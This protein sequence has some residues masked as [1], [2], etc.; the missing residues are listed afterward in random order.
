[1]STFF[2]DELLFSTAIPSVEELRARSLPSE[3]YEGYRIVKKDDYLMWKKAEDI[4]GDDLLV[5][6]DGDCR[7][8]LLP[9]DARLNALG[10]RK[11]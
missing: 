7:T 6:F 4:G 8:V 1:L 3:G 9:D 11:L 2:T 10:Y 5:F